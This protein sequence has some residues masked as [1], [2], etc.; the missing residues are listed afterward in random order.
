MLVPVHE[1]TFPT[2]DP[3]HSAVVLSSSAEHLLRHH[4]LSALVGSRRRGGKP[5]APGWKE[6]EFTQRQGGEIKE[7]FFLFFFI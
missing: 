3:S 2:V 7:D 4:H 5:D 1:L 6:S